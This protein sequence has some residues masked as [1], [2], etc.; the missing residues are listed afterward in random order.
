MCIPEHELNFCLKVAHTFRQQFLNLPTNHILCVNLTNSYTLFV[1]VAQRFMHY[2]SILLI[3]TNF[4]MK[5]Q[6]NLRKMCKLKCFCHIL[7]KSQT[8]IALCVK[9]Q[10]T[11]YSHA[12]ILYINC[13]L[14]MNCYPISGQN[15]KAF[16]L[17]FLFIYAIDKMCMG[18]PVATVAPNI[19]SGEQT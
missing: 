17:V 14:S 11:N 10:Q 5:Y 2:A 12:L 8:N 16:C 13:L 1:K 7:Y 6:I 18:P 15:Y 19:N 4:C 3:I 9:K